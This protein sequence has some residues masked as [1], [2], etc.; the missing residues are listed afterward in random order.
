MAGLPYTLQIALVWSYNIGTATAS[1]V[2]LLGNSRYQMPKVCL[3]LLITSYTV[4]HYITSLEFLLQFL[5]DFIS[6]KFQDLL[7]AV[8]FSMVGKVKEVALKSWMTWGK[9]WGNGFIICPQGTW[10]WKSLWPGTKVFLFLY[11]T[12][13]WWDRDILSK[14]VERPKS[15]NMLKISVDKFVSVYCCLAGF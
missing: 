4:D 6:E 12:I 7:I 11:S 9:W 15:V 13:Q 14:D 8:F 5:I 1:A 2:D 10:M 3:D